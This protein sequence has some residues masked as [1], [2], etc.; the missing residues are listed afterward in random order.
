MVSPIS[1]DDEEK[2][3]GRAAGTAFGAR[4]LWGSGKL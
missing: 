3:G 1:Y 2:R 4:W